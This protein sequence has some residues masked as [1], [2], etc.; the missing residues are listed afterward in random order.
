MEHQQPHILEKPPKRRKL[1]N[2]ENPQQLSHD[3]Y[4][5]G[6]VCALAIEAA[7]ATAMLDQIH[8][9]L[10]THPRDSNSYT[11]GSIGSHHVVI[12]C[13]PA[14]V[15]GTT[16]AATVASNMFISFGSIRHLL[17]VG[18]GGGVPS[19][20]ADI[21]LGDVVVSIPTPR[22]E[23]VVQYDYGKTIGQGRF[24]RTGTL[25]KPSIS[26]L[27]AVNSLRAADLRNGSQI[28]ILMSQMLARNTQM[29]ETF[30]SPGCQRD[31]LFASDYEHDPAE[32]TCEL[33]DRKNLVTRSMRNS[34]RPVVHYGLIASGNQVIKHAQTRDQL[35]AQLN[36]LCFEME[37]A[38]L[39]DNFPC[40]VIRGVSDYSD[41]HKNKA[42]QGYA[43]ATAAAY[44]KQLLAT[45]GVCGPAP[46]SGFAVPGAITAVQHRESMMDA[47][48]FDQL[49]SRQATIKSAHPKTCKWLLEKQEYV[50]WLDSNRFSEHCGFLWIKGKAGSG[51]STMIKFAFQRAND[52]VTA[53]T[54]VIS[55]FFNARGDDL[56]KSTLGMYR[57]LL[58]QLLEKVPEL[59][60][61]LDELDNGN[62]GDSYPWSHEILQHTFRRSISRLGGRRVICFVDALDECEEEEVRAM[63]DFIRSLGEHAISSRV[64]LHIC[65]SSRHYPHIAIEKG[66]ELILEDQEGHADDITRYLHSELK[67]GRSKQAEEIRREIHEKASGIFLWMVLVVQILNRE[68]QRGR[69]HALRKRLREIPAKLGDL[70]KDILTRDTVNMEDLLLSIQWILFARRPLKREEL[71][72]AILSADPDNLTEAWDP[73]D[74]SEQDIDRFILSTSKGL[75]ETT[76]SKAKT[77]QFIHESVRDFLL[78]EDGLRE[79]WPEHQGNF[80][81]SSHDRLKQC[82]NNTLF[83]EANNHIAD[84]E[85]I[86]SASRDE[87]KALCNSVSRKFPFLEY[88]V[89]NILQHSEAA[90]KGGIC[91]GSFLN[92]FNLA[93]WKRCSNT[94]ERYKARRHKESACLLYILARYDLSNL[95]RVICIDEP[96]GSIPRRG[97]LDFLVSYAVKNDRGELLDFIIRSQLQDASAF[98]TACIQVALLYTIKLDREAMLVNLLTNTQFGF[99]SP[100]KDE[101]HCLHYIIQYD[102]V[103]MFNRISAMHEIDLNIAD[104]NGNRPLHY[105]IQ[106]DRKAMFANLLTNTRVNLKLPN[107][108]KQQYLHSIIEYGRSS[109]FDEIIE[110]RE[111]DLNAPD[112][113]GDTPLH[114]TIRFGQQYMF[115]KLLTLDQIDLSV[116]NRANQT[117]LH[118]ALQY[119]RENMFDIL[120]ARDNAD[121]TAL[122]FSAIELYDKLTFNRLITTQPVNVNAMNKDGKT[123]LTLAIERSNFAIIKSL[124]KTSYTEV[125]LSDKDWNRTL[126]CAALNR[127]EEIVELLVTMDD[128]FPRLDSPCAEAVLL[129]AAW[130]GHKALMDKV[131]ATGKADPNAM[132]L[133]GKTVLTYSASGGYTD[134]A[135]QLLSKESVDPDAKDND[136][137]T[138]LAHAASKGYTDIAIQLL[139]KE[140]VEPD[141]KDRYGRTPLAHAASGG[142]ADIVIQLL[143]TGRIEVD[144][145]DLA[146]RTPLAYAVSG[147]HAAVV[148]I[149]LSTGKADP[150]HKDMCGFTPLYEAAASGV[151]DVVGQLLEIPRADIMSAYASGQKALCM[152]KSYGNV[153]VMMMLEDWLTSFPYPE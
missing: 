110:M 49:E 44:A 97:G 142:Y 57:S 151:E 104:G 141:A 101:K 63:I 29:A 90:E 92:N 37:A 126:Q 74:I 65:F 145:V 88:A 98:T 5:I 61:L 106:F 85:Y 116:Q 149:L 1:D 125:L 96:C 75:A 150:N 83:S 14:G 60:V 13:L 111:I 3:D 148:R 41:S 33:C 2:R 62:G 87:L 79:L 19:A 89:H 59:Q 102:R 56:E 27:T 73:E 20:S 69:L 118:C 86:A 24:E 133:D 66:L 50:N 109:M 48:R 47:L 82:C 136:G 51:K 36:I 91:Q 52:T 45:I 23:G 58:A 32:P 146:G 139:S 34:D 53:E 26:L 108:N 99:Q 21:R 77:V 124:L 76:K 137:R 55:F 107:K 114:Y 4:T 153:R 10:S 39:M 135:I 105:T 152:A 138:P 128:L 25:N 115:T 103:S 119:G 80:E 11:L 40:L 130:G 28:P 16:S 132:D 8:P 123:L 134:I 67:I 84:E 17:M 95:I 120:I 121:I 113:N 31:L 147:G 78:K 68:Y 122:L 64:Q 127:R 100:I 7:A 6:W 70:F 42:W 9:A 18:I 71:Y 22:F 30:T 140:S 72:F 12:A 35:A 43:A 129:Y 94:F 46:I 131:L 81:A 144:A 54:D 38:G 143:S 112:M 15:Y 117:L 93:R